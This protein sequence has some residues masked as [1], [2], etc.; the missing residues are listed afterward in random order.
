MAYFNGDTIPTNQVQIIPGAEIYHFGILTSSIHMSWMR[1]VAG[2][3]KSDYRYSGSVVYNNFVWC[4]PTEEQKSLIEATAQRILDVRSK[5]PN[6]MLAD[7][8]DELTMPQDL[9]DAHKKNDRAVAAA[10]GFENLLDD[11]SKIVA[12]LM[13]LYE[14][15]TNLD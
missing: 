9:R 11:E 6:A 14:Q 5:Y 2:R 3:L 7:L 10:Y 15:L 13:K 1:A 12:E 4:D 8:Y